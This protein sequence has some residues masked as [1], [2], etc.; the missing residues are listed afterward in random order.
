MKVVTDWLSTSFLPYQEGYL[1][2]IP[3][4]ITRDSRVAVE[5]TGRAVKANPPAISLIRDPRVSRVLKALWGVDLPAQEHIPPFRL[6]PGD[7]IFLVEPNPYIPLPE[8]VLSREE[9]EELGLT[10]WLIQT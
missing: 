3:I 5:E 6:R 7:L 9:V 8:E 1:H 4:R 10:I 2:L